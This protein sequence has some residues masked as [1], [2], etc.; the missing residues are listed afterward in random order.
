M[1]V[2]SGIINEEIGFHTIGNS[3]SLSAL[4]SIFERFWGNHARWYG[5][6]ILDRTQWVNINIPIQG[7]ELL[8]FIHVRTYQQRDGLSHYQNLTSLSVSGSIL[9]DF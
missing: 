4:G 8:G 7:L 3:T 2:H 9:K 1:Y 6:H 5:S